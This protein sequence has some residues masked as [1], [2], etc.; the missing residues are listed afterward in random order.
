MKHLEDSL[1]MA[2]AANLL[3]YLTGSQ[4]IT[5]YQYA[6]NTVAIARVLT[7]P[8]ILTLFVILV[9]GFSAAFLVPKLPL[10]IPRRDF[11]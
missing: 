11:G 4:L 10:G 7:F 5:A 3:P 6:D 9:L 1:G 2:D 8:T